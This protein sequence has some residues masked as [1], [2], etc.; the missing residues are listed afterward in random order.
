MEI[1]PCFL[2]WGSFVN[3][4]SSHVIEMFQT[5]SLYPCLLILPK[6]RYGLFL[7]LLGGDLAKPLELAWVSL[8]TPGLGPHQIRW[9]LRA[10]W[11]QLSLQRGWRWWPAT[12]VPV[13]SSWRSPSKNPGRPGSEELPGGRYCHILLP[14]DVGSVC[15]FIGTRQLKVPSG[16]FPDAVLCISTLVWFKTVAFHCNK[17]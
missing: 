14:G 17:P 8:L 16:T 2:P 5:Q 1:F 11:Q 12:W 4:G 7:G 3:V 13:S 9:R 6:E 10:L 15:S